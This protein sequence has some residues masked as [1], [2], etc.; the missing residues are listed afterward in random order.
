MDP[1]TWAPVT[2]SVGNLL[3]AKLNVI[4]G[5]L[6]GILVSGIL[7][8]LTYLLDQLNVYC[9]VKLVDVKASKSKPSKIQEN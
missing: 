8:S 7:V 4:I 9:T 3:S 6:T 2:E 1:D 5:I